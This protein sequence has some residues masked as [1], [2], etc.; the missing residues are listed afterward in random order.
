MYDV[1]HPSITQCMSR[2]ALIL[3]H[4]RV[5]ILFKFHIEN[6]N[7]KTEK[8]TWESRHRLKTMTLEMNVY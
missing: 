2:K 8:K 6:N 7:N 1:H 5:Y 3:Y 4:V